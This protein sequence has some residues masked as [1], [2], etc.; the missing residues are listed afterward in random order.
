MGI[1]AADRRTV[2]DI[3][4]DAGGWDS[5]GFDVGDWLG[6]CVDQAAAFLGRTSEEVSIL[7]TDDRHIKRLNRDFRHQDS[8]TN[9]LAFPTAGGPPHTVGDGPPGQLVG[10]IVLAFETVSRECRKT[11]RPMAHHMAHLCIHG[12]LHLHGFDHLNDSDAAAMERAEVAILGL[13]DIASPY[14]QAGS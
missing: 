9:V 1:T 13:L 7:L 5:L 14:R 10:D 6:R 4:R 11:G 2:V 3:A 8:A 12:Y